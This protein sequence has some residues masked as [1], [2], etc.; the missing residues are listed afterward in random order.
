M[1]NILIYVEPHPI[2]KTH[3]SFMEVARFFAHIV[4]RS[5]SEFTV[6]MIV[7]K[8]TRESLVSEFP[9]TANHTLEMPSRFQTFIDNQ[10]ITSWEDND[11]AQWM[12]MLNGNGYADIYVD[13]L[14]EIDA[15]FPI[16]IIVY[17]GANGAVKKFC[18]QRN[19][20][21]IAMELGCS[22]PPHLNAIVFD[23]VGVNGDSVHN[24]L[25]IH[26]IRKI[27]DDANLQAGPLLLSPQKTSNNPKEEALLTEINN[28]KKQCDGTVLTCLQLHD[29][30]NLIRYAKYHSMLEFLQEIV[31]TLDKKNQL[32][33]VKEHPLAH[34]RIGGK[35]ISEEI[36]HYLA[37]FKNT[38]F[39]PC[40]QKVCN[41]KLITLSDIIITIN[42]S[43]GYEAAL[44]KK[45]VI[46]MG[47]ACYKPIGL[48]PT[49]NDYFIN[50]H[51]SHAEYVNNIAHLERYFS[52]LVLHAANLAFQPH[53]FYLV[54]CAITKAYQQA[55]GNITDYC[56][57][58][59]QLQRIPELAYWHVIANTQ[60]KNTQ[61]REA[62]FSQAK[63]HIK[64]QYPRL[65]RLLRTLKKLFSAPE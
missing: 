53:Y 47:E 7:N 31:P 39:I 36:S 54:I 10:P 55:Q 17:W 6:K 35:A 64:T 13:L 38:V 24:K 33:I 65:S 60:Q 50:D 25:T 8:K 46:V 29:D 5:Q 42:S 44:H 21:S 58:L 28:R 51:F 16:D 49:F 61:P 45:I 32:I 18:Q 23:P 15:T 41:L 19:I 14:T 52:N 3:F 43:L 57:Y 11:I 1:K 56:R 48:F 37:G 22:R 9:D 40:T 59:S 20:P 62:F 26:D 12:E 34:E 2:R 30:L 4:S 27:V 63:K